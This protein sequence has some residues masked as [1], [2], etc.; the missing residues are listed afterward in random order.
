V[1]NRVCCV[2][3]P[4]SG[5]ATLFAGGFA[6]TVTLPGMAVDTVS[7]PLAFL[8]AR[9]KKR[10]CFV[11]EVNKTPVVVRVFS[12]GGGGGGEEALS[13]AAVP[14]KLIMVKQGFS[15]YLHRTACSSRM[16]EGPRDSE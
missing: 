9:T 14:V 8:G 4:P 7:F 16:Q 2:R 15:R 3:L 12:S 13:P 1:R 5:H 10:Q 11:A 6:G